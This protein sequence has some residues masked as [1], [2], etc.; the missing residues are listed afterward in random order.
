MSKYS[1]L[2]AKHKEE[3]ER[4]KQS[5]ATRAEDI[6]KSFMPKKVIELNKLLDSE[7]FSA[8]FSKIS[9]PIIFDRDTTADEQPDSDEHSGKKR[10]LT[11][12]TQTS[13]KQTEAADSH[14]RVKDNTSV[15][16]NPHIIK[17][18]DVLKA[19]VLEFI[20]TLTAVRIWVQ[21]NIP[22]IE[23]GNNFGVSIQEETLN[24]LA[25]AEENAFSSLDNIPKYFLNRAR[26]ITKILKYPGISDYRQSVIELDEKVYIKAVLILK[27]VRDNYSIF[28]DMIVKNWAKI[29]KP[30]SDNESTLY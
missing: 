2:D 6:V 16:S 23:D 9:T 18:F 13:I 17:V 4:I 14:S 27:E 30:R 22:R 21:L 29:R 1:L 11:E 12:T 20:E 10:K 26:Y 25:R 28:H 7:D 5:I 15:S 8:D 3:I 24:E 19:N